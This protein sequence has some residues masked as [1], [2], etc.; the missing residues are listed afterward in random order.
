MN[1]NQTIVGTNKYGK[2]YKN[3]VGQSMQIGFKVE[4]VPNRDYGYRGFQAFVT[5]CEYFFYN[6]F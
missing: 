4:D 5:M 1:D 3:S 6:V 2:K